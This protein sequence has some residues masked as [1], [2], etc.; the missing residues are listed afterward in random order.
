MNKVV[1]LPLLILPACASPGENARLMQAAL[2]HDKGACVA[3]GNQPGTDDYTRCMVKLGHRE[4]YLV[5]QADDGS[6]VF[7]LPQTDGIS[8]ETSPGINLRADPSARP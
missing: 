8:P 2:D 4:G 1:L 5:A 7:A 3:R 6:Y